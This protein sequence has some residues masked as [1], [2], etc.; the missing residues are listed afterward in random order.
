MCL[1]FLYTVTFIFKLCNV[2]VIMISMNDVS[3][4]LFLVVFYLN[5]IALITKL[6]YFVMIGAIF[7]SICH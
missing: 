5:N 2:Q 1:V 4:S 3:F 6:R 7:P